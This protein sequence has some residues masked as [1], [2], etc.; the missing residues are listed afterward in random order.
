MS[1]DVASTQNPVESNMT[2]ESLNYPDSLEEAFIPP[3]KSGLTG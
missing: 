1:R 2:D 3:C